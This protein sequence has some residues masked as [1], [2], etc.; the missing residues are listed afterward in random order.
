MHE[1][2]DTIRVSIQVFNDVTILWRSMVELLRHA[3]TGDQL[4]LVGLPEVLA[5]LTLPANMAVPDRSRLAAVLGAPEVPARI[6]GSEPLVC[7]CGA[8]VPGHWRASGRLT[9]D[10]DWMDQL[11]REK[12][13]RHALGGDVLLLVCA[14]GAEQHAQA[15]RI[16]LRHG[17]HNLQ[18]HEFTL[19]GSRA[20]KGEDQ[21]PKKE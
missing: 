14:T 17:R 6:G 18:T 15:G 2:P 7:R 1:G 9:A 10:F 12:L 5:G 13:I 3:L 21:S 8:A 4:C 11:L 20:G 16:L 19:R